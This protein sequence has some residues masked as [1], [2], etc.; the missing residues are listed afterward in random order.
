MC[1]FLL[2]L[3]TPVG[4]PAILQDPVEL[5]R[6]ADDQHRLADQALRLENLLRALEE[7]ARQEGNDTLAN[8]LQ[9]ARSRIREADGAEGLVAALEGAAVDL[10]GL[11]S[12][13]ALAIQAEAIARL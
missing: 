1:I 2:L 12:G 8:L 10:G 4:S 6:L 7:R 3:P 13:P 5:K 11:R 9:K